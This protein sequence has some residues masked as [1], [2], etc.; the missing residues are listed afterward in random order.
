[1]CSRCGSMSRRNGSGRRCTGRSK[2][3]GASQIDPGCAKTRAFNLLVESSSQFGQFENQKCWRR[4]SEKGNRETGST[5][6]WL[7]HVFARPGPKA[8]IPCPRETGV[9]PKADRESGIADGRAQGSQIPVAAWSDPRKVV[10]GAADAT[11][12]LRATP[13]R[14]TP[15]ELRRLPLLHSR[16]REERM[17]EDKSD[18]KSGARSAAAK[19]G[20][21]RRHLLL[22][23]TSLVAT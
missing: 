2:P 10:K 17:T 14:S 11:A 23:T 13:S 5:L 20:I 21:R 22:S 15:D 3:V 6:S 9:A 12:R 16:Q 4:L 19:I 8:V 18:K 7:A 1:V